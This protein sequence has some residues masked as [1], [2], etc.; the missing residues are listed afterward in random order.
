MI[1]FLIGMVPSSIEA[2]SEETE[3]RFTSLETKITSMEKTLTKLV[4][5]VSVKVHDDMCLYASHFSSALSVVMRLP[6]AQ[7]L[8]KLVSVRFIYQG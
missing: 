3:S 4:M 6:S 1:I 7:S 8:L 2:S 5:V